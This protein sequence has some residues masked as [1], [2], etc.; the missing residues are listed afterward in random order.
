M[1]TEILEQPQNGSVEIAQRPSMNLM[2]VDDPVAVIERA[3]RVATALGELIL[4]RSLFTEIH[5]KKYVHLDGWQVA[6]TMLGVVAVVTGTEE[7]EGGWKATA[8]ARTLDG[9]VI[10]AAESICTRDEKRGPWKSA[11]GYALIAMA[12]TRAMS[13]ALRGPLGFIL[14]LSGYESTT[15]EDADSIAPEPQQAPDERTTIPEE[16]A[17]ELLALYERSPH[18]A[19]ALKMKMASIG[20]HDTS[21][22]KAAIYS[23]ADGQQDEARAWIMEG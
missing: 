1:T 12:Q 14:K 7:I 13:R 16:D 21:T 8:E 18:K 10:G 11:E 9:R 2:G 6:G 4:R 20:A 5:N 22:A 23:L 3:S 15:A 17:A 19:D